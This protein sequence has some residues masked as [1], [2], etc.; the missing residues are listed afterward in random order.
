MRD[1]PLAVEA[2]S[3]T[4]STPKAF[5][6]FCYDEDKGRV[7]TMYQGWRARHPHVMLDRLDSMVAEKANALGE[8]E[9]KRAIRDAVDQTSVTCVL[10]GA[11]TW[12]DRW[13]RSRLRAP[14]SAAAVCWPSESTGFPTRK[15]A[16][17]L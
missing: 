12:Q 10:L 11:H 17:Q 4:P 5:F 2:T 7:D 3:K 14:S 16:K 15:Q 1:L 6:S 9:I 8:A 13:V